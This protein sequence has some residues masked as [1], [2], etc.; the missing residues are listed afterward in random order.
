MPISKTVPRDLIHTRSIKC[1]G[2]KRKDGLWDIDGCMEDTKTYSFKNVDRDH[3]ASGEPIH[4]MV[5]RITVD[6]EMVVQNAEASTEFAPYHICGNVNNNFKQLKGLK[7]GPGWRRA[8][9]QAMG[10]TLGCTHLRDLLIG[11]LAVTA[12]Q[13]IIPMRQLSNPDKQPTRR[14]AIIGTCH[15]Y[16]PDGPIVERLWP[17]FYEGQQ[18]INK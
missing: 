12:Y 6:D 16:A 3:I 10:G 2:Y 9:H 1:A 13:T 17:Q 4:H 14:P 7:I 8:V 15:A 5:M 11:P 18:N